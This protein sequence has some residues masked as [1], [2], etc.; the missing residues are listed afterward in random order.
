MHR[1]STAADAGP[2][3]FEIVTLAG[4]FTRSASFNREISRIADVATTGD[5]NWVM[6]VSAVAGTRSICRFAA[7]IAS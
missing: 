6:S 4:M 7:F 1:R 3:T 5:V 2:G